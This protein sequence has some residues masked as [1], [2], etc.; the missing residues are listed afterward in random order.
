MNNNGNIATLAP[1]RAMLSQF[2]FEGCDVPLEY[3]TDRTSGELNNKTVDVV[4][5]PLW[6]SWDD[7]F[8]AKT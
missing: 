6:D 5:R 2:T 8:K 7:C 3:V 1:V 4:G